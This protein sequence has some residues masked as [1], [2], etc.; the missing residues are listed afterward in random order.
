MASRIL[1][2]DDHEATRRGIADLIEHAGEEWIVA[3]EAPDGRS[4]IDIAVGCKPDLVIMDVRMPKLDGF[5]AAREIRSVYPLVP[6]LFYTLL[7]TPAL[8]LSALS[9]GYQGV[10]AKPDTR[11][12]LNAMRQLLPSKKGGGSAGGSGSNKPRANPGSAAQAG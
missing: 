9:A 12:L 11:A 1:V 3:C 6:V 4:A 2:V 5:R 8:E 10:I 7:A